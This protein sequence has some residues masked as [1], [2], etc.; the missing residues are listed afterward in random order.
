MWC[1]RWEVCSARGGCAVRSGDVCR[2]KAGRC[3]G[4]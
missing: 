2:V 1:E 3:N 4:W